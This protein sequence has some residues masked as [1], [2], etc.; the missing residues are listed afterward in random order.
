M[1][2][3][4][5]VIT[6]CLYPVLVLSLDEV[7]RGDKVAAMS[8]SDDAR[9]DYGKCEFEGRSPNVTTL[10][11]I[12]SSLDLCRAACEEK[13]TCLI[14][15]MRNKVCYLQIVQ[16]IPDKMVDFGINCDLDSSG[17]CFEI[18]SYFLMEE[19]TIP[20]EFNVE[21][22]RKECLYHGQ[23]LMWKEEYMY[24]KR[25]MQCTLTI[26]TIQEIVFG[27][28]HAC[29]S[30]TV[31]T[32]TT[33]HT[34]DTTTYGPITDTITTITVIEHQECKNSSIPLQCLMYNLL[35]EENR[36]AD[37][38]E[39]VPNKFRCDSN[40]TTAFHQN[41]DPNSNGWKGEG[42]YRLAGPA[43]TKI[44]EGPVGKNKCGTSGTGWMVDTH[45]TDDY[46]TKDVRFCF[47]WRN[48]DQ[49]PNDCRTENKGKVTN[50]GPY[51]VYNLENV[52]N[53]NQRY[54]GVPPTP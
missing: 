26:L 51:Y 8:L 13:L 25:Y 32:T 30:T 42:W 12:G 18:G 31:K 5:L 52:P 40:I 37:Y 28:P 9:W 2:S 45:P 29:P 54:C 46:A 38:Y 35:L 4:L 47:Q 20:V 7:D 39:K 10:K 1:F 24:P 34:T 43:G 23:C 49:T 41:T 44:P 33:P 6:T 27:V 14:W 19:I 22:C 15:E 16:S 36:S 11:L 17:Y 3:K 21:A 53:C 48:A 50:C